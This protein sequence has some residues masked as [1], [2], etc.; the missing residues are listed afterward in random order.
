M[1]CCVA[2]SNLNIWE[3]S[4]K[5]SSFSIFIKGVIYCEENEKSIIA[6]DVLRMCILH[7]GIF[8]GVKS[9]RHFSNGGRTADR[10]GRCLRIWS[11]RCMYRTDWMGRMRTACF[12]PR[13]LLLRYP[14]MSNLRRGKSGFRPLLLVLCQPGMSTLRKT[15][16]LWFRIL[17]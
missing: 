10:K 16:R 7:S 17:R 11:G 14:W 8:T 12:P 5:A 9:H 15:L 2:G 13:F 6:R 1:N 4:K 3:R